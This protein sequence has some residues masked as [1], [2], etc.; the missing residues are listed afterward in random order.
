MAT[1]FWAKI[2]V[3]CDLLSDDRTRDDIN[4][5]HQKIY[6]RVARM[7]YASRPGPSMEM[8]VGGFRTLYVA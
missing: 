8:I 5:E 4:G 3:C 6:M 1:A 2:F 7:G